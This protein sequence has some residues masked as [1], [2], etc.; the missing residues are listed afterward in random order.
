[1][2]IPKIYYN[3]RFAAADVLSGSEASDGNPVRRV[4]DGDLSLKYYLF[5]SPGDPVSGTVHATM[6]AATLPTYFVQARATAVSGYTI[7]VF[8]SDY[9]GGNQAQHLETT[10]SG[11]DSF[12]E[13]LSGADTARRCWWVEYSTEVSGLGAC[14]LYEVMLADQLELPRSPEVGVT[15]TTVQ[16]YQQMAIPGAASFKLRLGEDYRKVGYS[17]YLVSG[18]EVDDVETFLQTNDG[19]EPFWFVNDLG[20]EYWAELQGPAHE[21]DDQAGVYGYG[22]VINEVPL[23]Q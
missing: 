2:G 22:L 6:A 17:L 10:L 7:K 23:E 11:D 19:G 5:D 20:S 1:M 3:N 13:V 21:F 4:A 14:N 12:V 18:T 15:R 9:G 8:S 16:N